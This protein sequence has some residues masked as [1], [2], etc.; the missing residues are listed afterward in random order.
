[1]GTGPH[2]A[3]PQASG[4]R[5]EEAGRVE[6]DVTICPGGEGECG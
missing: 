1:M 2:V 3:S 4:R 6:V 5:A